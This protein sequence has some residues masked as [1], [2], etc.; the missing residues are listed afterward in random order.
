[1]PF[2]KQYTLPINLRNLG[3]FSVP[4]F[5]ETWKTIYSGYKLRSIIIYSYKLSSVLTF[6]SSWRLKQEPRVNYIYLICISWFLKYRFH[7][8][9]M[10]PSQFQ[11]TSR[12]PLHLF[13]DAYHSGQRLYQIPARNDLRC[14][15]L[16]RFWITTITMPTYPLLMSF[17]SSRAQPDND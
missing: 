7:F 15:Y 8:H 14:T 1:M 10:H 16:R 5:R 3:L 13:L 2:L 4:P 17:R 6:S 11:L 12:I 9:P